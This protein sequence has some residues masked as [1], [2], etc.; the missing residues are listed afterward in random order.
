VHSLLLSI[1]PEHANKIFSGSKKVELRRV[2]PKLS[3]ADTVLVYVSSPVKALVGGFEVDEVIE[4]SPDEI[5]CQVE[6]VAGISKDEFQ[7]Y[8]AGTNKAFAIMIN[9]TWNLGAPLS[10]LELKAKWLNFHPP[11]SYRYIT[12]EQAAALGI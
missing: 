11:Q 5:W 6:K 1:R 7:K 2:K 4:G 12:F 9:K 3:K 8:F 10:L